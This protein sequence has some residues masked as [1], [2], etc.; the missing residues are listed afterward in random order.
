MFPYVDG[1]ISSGSSIVPERITTSLLGKNKIEIIERRLITKILQEKYLSQTGVVDST[2][3]KQIGSILGVEAVVTGT[4]I[5]LDNGYTEINA[6]MIRVETGEI[7]SAAAALVPKTWTDS[8]QMPTLPRKPTEKKTLRGADQPE[9][10]VRNKITNTQLSNE[11]FPGGRRRYNRADG[12]PPPDKGEP[13]IDVQFPLPSSPP[14]T[15]KP[16]E[17][18]GKPTLMQKRT[19]EFKRERF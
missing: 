9:A 12:P 14:K 1:K 5:D 8:P 16:P 10:P 17:K 15:V 11:N 6:R 7:L 13:G 19:E 2:E 18:Q 3:V 4:L